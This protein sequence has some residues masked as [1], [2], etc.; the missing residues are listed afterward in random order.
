M[1]LNP[2]EQNQIIYY[3]RTYFNHEA[4]LY[5]F[6]SR[7]DDSKKGG[8]I[9]LFLDSP[10]DVDMQTQIHFLTAIYRHVTERKVDLLINSPSKK[11]QAIYLAAK[12]T[13]VLLC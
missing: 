8:D 5:L 7:A 2:K 6:G 11:P 12:E 4:K 3:A 13:G 1:R 10:T 9:D